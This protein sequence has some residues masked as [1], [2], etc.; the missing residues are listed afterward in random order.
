MRVL[1][2]TSVWS[3]ALRR[4]GP[5]DHPAVRKLS[6]LLLDN[7]DVVLIGVVL[8]EMLQAFRDE[9]TVRKVSAHLEPF[10]MLPLSREDFAAAAA[11]YR[12]CASR[13]V[14]A[15]TIDC[16]IATAAIN[17]DCLLLTADRDFERL[18]GHSP[19]RLL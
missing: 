11:L 1:V 9:A 3:L 13:G 16:L 6:T 19:L 5:T 2:D 10:P 15:S 4:S 12:R 7:E 14:S 18:A 8:Q 17:H